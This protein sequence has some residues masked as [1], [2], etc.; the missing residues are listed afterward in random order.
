MY[1]AVSLNLPAFPM[2]IWS[3]KRKQIK[4]TAQLDKLKTRWL[5]GTNHKRYVKTKIDWIW[6]GYNR[7]PV[8]L[9]R[10]VT[11]MGRRKLHFEKQDD[12]S[13]TYNGQIR[14]VART[15]LLDLFGWSFTKHHI[16][17]F[18]PCDRS[19]LITCGKDAELSVTTKNLYPPPTPVFARRRIHYH[20][21]LHERF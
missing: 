10:K 16:H 15:Y 21:L 3:G 9:Y 2:I 11:G 1:D 7:I 8:K 17:G 14:A 19:P 6:M 18:Q 20:H 12:E 5:I 4:R 13:C